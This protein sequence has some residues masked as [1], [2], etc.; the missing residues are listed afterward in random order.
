MRKH[1]GRPS[2]REYSFNVNEFY[3]IDAIG[4]IKEALL[5]KLCYTA[6]LSESTLACLHLIH[7]S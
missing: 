1:N 3:S 5:N 2:S 4:Y 6:F 7:R